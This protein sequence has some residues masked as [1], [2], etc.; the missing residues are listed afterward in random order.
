[1]RVSRKT[2]IAGSGYIDTRT[3]YRYLKSRLPTNFDRTKAVIP[4]T[5][6]A[7]SIQLGSKGALKIYVMQIR[8]VITERLR[9][10]FLGS[11]NRV[12]W[13]LAQPSY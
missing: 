10:E 9:N 7:Q 1:V 12:P 3:S 13:P 6:Y 5:V 4:A 11:V 2:P 8:C